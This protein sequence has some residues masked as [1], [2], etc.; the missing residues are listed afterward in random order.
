[1]VKSSTVTNFS[2]VALKESTSI[3]K[4][5]WGVFVQISGL[6]R[7]VGLTAFEV[8]LE[9]QIKLNCETFE[10]WTWSV[11]GWH[12]I[13]LFVFFQI[14][15]CVVLKHQNYFVSKLETCNTNNESFPSAAKN[16]RYWIITLNLT[17]FEFYH[18]SCGVILGGL[19]FSN[20]CG[21]CFGIYWRCVF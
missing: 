20:L 14:E 4:V 16:D 11:E 8:T 2:E 1:M 18:A 6:L 19:K 9:R 21:F 7:T 13:S 3:N 5:R 12:H 17:V 10:W 15:S